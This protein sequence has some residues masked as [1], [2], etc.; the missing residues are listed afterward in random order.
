[1]RPKT[2]MPLGLFVC[3]LASLLGSSILSR[4]LVFRWNDESCTTEA[5]ELGP[6]LN[7]RSVLLSLSF[8]LAILTK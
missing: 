6:Q 3:L 1:M 5:M 7:T 4:P 2:N 8:G